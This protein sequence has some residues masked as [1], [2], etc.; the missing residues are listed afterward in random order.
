MKHLLW[1]VK[2][3]NCTSECDL[4][5]IDHHHLGNRFGN[6]K[7]RIEGNSKDA[8]NHIIEIIVKVSGTVL[9]SASMITSGRNVLSGFW[10]KLVNSYSF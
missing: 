4:S 5:V 9:A 1:T 7:C 2:Y 3:G 6:E 10:M 8:C